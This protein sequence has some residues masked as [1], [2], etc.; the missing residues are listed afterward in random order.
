MR[1]IE[2]NLKYIKFEN[3]YFIKIFNLLIYIVNHLNFID[4]KL[5]H[6]TC[7]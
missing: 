5:I 2:I 3:Y 1:K 6:F 4:Q 7:P